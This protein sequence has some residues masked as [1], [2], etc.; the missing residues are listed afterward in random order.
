[1]PIVQRIQNICLKPKQE[2]DVIAGETTSTADLLKNYALPL[3]AI[4]SVAGFIGMSFIG[5]TLPFI[6]TFRTPVA[7][8]LVGAVVSL[9]MALVGVY[10]IG[11]I[12]NALAPKFGGEKNSGQAL[13]LA[14]Y[15]ST[16][17]WVAGVLRILPSLGILAAL[18]AIYGLY[19]LYLGLPKLMKNPPEKSVTYT[20]VIVVCAIVLFFVVG[21]ITSAVIGAGAMG[22]GAALPSGLR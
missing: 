19:L 16:P 17:G 21:A 4:G 11:L 3:A 10:V 6:G 13:K 9:V 7:T 14:V 12:I 8:G 15:A 18:A 1:M 20:V 22:G 5:V 2:W